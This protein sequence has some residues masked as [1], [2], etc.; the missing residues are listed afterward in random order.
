MGEGS[1]IK[2][3]NDLPF[4]ADCRKKDNVLIAMFIQNCLHDKNSN[5]VR[6]IEE[7]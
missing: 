5:R 6:A 2:E 4:V 1:E 3:L 7:G